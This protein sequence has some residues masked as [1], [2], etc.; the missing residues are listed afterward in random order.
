MGISKNFL[1]IASTLVPVCFPGRLLQLA[2]VSSRFL[3]LPLSY[4]VSLGY[5][6]LRGKINILDRI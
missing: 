1:F 4:S 3:E 6:N 5:G 2:K